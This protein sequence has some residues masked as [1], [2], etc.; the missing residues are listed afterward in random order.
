MPGYFDYFSRIS[1]LA[2][3]AAF[4]LK[5]LSSAPGS[6]CTMFAF[7]GVDDPNL[8]HCTHKYFGEGTAKKA[9]VI[10]ELERHF[11]EKPFKPFKVPF[12]QI[13]H[14]GD[15]TYRVAKPQTTEPFLLDLKEKLDDLEKDSWPEYVPHVT[16]GRN[17]DSID[18][19]IRDYILMEDHKE[20]WS[21]SKHMKRLHAETAGF[22]N[23]G[24]K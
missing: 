24:K 22:F 9:E 15:G 13:D 2:R 10:R 6:L 7:E 21:A 12:D 23:K 4:G 16:V 8:L 17:T 14:L 18:K 20:V 11:S 5:R 19:P 3:Q 1:T